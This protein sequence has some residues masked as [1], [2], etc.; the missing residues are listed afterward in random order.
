MCVCVCESLSRVQLLAAPWT[1]PG[2]SVHR[3]LQAR[4]LQWVA[5]PFSRGSSQLKDRTRVSYLTG[6]FFLPSALPGKPNSNL[7]LFFLYSLYSG[8]RWVFIA[9]HWVSPVSAHRLLTAVAPVVVQGGLEGSGF[10]SC[11]RTALERR[12]SSCG[13]RASLPL[14]LLSFPWN[15]P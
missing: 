1:P 8:V 11:S 2:S 15:L 5:I 10:R 4:T 6:R 3:I 7:D 12:L 14:G 9:D 13:G